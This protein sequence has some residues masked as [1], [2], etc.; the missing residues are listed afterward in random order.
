[1][2]KLIILITSLIMMSGSFA[3]A[4]IPAE[5]LEPYKA[6]RAAEKAGEEVKARKFAKTAWEKSEELL[7]DHKTTGDLAFNYADISSQDDVRNPYKNY[8]VRR[9]AFLRSV[10]LSSFYEEDRAGIE[11]ERLIKLTE[12]GLTLTKRT[13]GS[14][15][16]GGES[17]D[18]KK[19]KDAIEKYDMVG[20]VFEGDYEALL[21]QRYLLKGQN[22]KAIEHADM[23]IE[24]FE[25]REDKFFSS[26]EYAVRVFK[27]RSY[28]N[29]GENISSA[30]EFQHVM[31]NVEGRLPA[32]H[33]YV[34]SALESWMFMR[35][36]IVDD[37]RLEEAEQAG[38][39]ECWPFENYK[40]KGVPL[41][42][43][44]PRMPSSANR[45]GHVVV[46]FDLD[47]N[48]QPINI[49][50]LSATE[51]IFVRPAL[52]SVEKWRYN[53][54][55]DEKEGVERTGI[56]TRVTFRLA[57]SQGNIIAER[58]PSF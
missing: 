36:K 16:Q 43:V 15:V 49:K 53:K 45:S 31:Q 10:E 5:V 51:S 29:M 34:K 41:E 32:D 3:Q 30:L 40:N 1:M 20:S 19:L 35:S 26:Y 2:K 50:E 18:F 57:D 23:A 13:N 6:Y 4:K 54:I 7:G 14:T 33:S 8:K 47:K 48:G 56:T 12:L 38:L 22:E 28:R 27:A 25:N 21:S 52:K 44:P 58:A 42:R 9:K 55:E 39:C 37:G 24:I 11:L 17:S 46:Q